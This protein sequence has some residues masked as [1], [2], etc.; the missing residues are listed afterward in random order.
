MLLQIALHQSVGS[1]VHVQVEP[2]HRLL[3][4]FDVKPTLIELARHLIS[5]VTQVLNQFSHAARRVDVGIIVLVLHGDASLPRGAVKHGP[6]VVGNKQTAVQAPIHVSEPHVGVPH[7]GAQ[8]DV[9]LGMEACLAV[10]HAVIQSEFLQVQ[11]TDINI[12]SEDIVVVTDGAMG[13]GVKVIAHM[14]A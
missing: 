6:C 1:H 4:A 9:T 7:L 12:G 14:I 11:I 2:G 13:V 8:V 3:E 10:A 5:G